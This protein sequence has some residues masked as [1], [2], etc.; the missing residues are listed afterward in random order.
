[1]T[2]RHPL[3]LVHVTVSQSNGEPEADETRLHF[4]ELNTDDTRYS[5]CNAEC[6]AAQ[7]NTSDLKAKATAASVSTDISHHSVTG[8]PERLN[9]VH[10]CYYRE[11]RI[12]FKCDQDQILIFNNG[13]LCLSFIYQ[14]SCWWLTRDFP[15]TVYQIQLFHLVD[16]R[17][18]LRICSVSADRNSML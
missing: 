4:S 15:E 9:K 14:T 12:K 13:L 8:C 1:M 7:G 5:F 18:V 6:K 11:M 16:I 17:E 3:L 2:L 10:F